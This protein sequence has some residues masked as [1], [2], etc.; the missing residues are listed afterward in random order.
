MNMQ[1]IVSLATLA[2]VGIVTLVFIYVIA[3]SG[4]SDDAAQVQKQSNFIRRW[5]FWVLI[6]FGIGVAW[7]T[8]KPFPIPDQYNALKAAQVVDVV[9]HQWYWTIS[10]KELEAGTPVEFRVTSNDVNHGFAV[11]APD[12]R[13]V[14]QTQAMPD[15]TNKLLYTFHTPGTYRVLCLEYCGVA[16][17]AM[18]TQFTVV[19][20]KTG[21]AS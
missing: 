6:L 13:I 1:D 15:Y 8:L 12:N 11:Y 5:W 16:H 9:G 21:G 10:R 18:E 17:H 4:K 14:V 3:Q 20:A 7:G 2:G 19:T